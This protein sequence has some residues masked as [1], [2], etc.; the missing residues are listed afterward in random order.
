[1]LSQLPSRRSGAALAPGAH[2]LDGDTQIGR[3]IIHGPQ[4][5]DTRRLV[6]C[7]STTFSARI[8]KQQEHGSPFRRSREKT[9]AALFHVTATGYPRSLH[10]NRQARFIEKPFP[11]PLTTGRAIASTGNARS[12]VRPGTALWTGAVAAAPVSGQGPLRT[13][14][15]RTGAGP[16]NRLRPR[17]HRISLAAQFLVHVVLQRG[18]GVEGPPVRVVAGCHHAAHRSDGRSRRSPGAGGVV[19]RRV[20]RLAA[21]NSSAVTTGGCTH[22]C[23]QTQH[24]R[25][26]RR[27]WWR[28]PQTWRPK[29][30]GFR[31]TDRTTPAVQTPG[32]P[33]SGSS[34]A[35][36][37]AAVRQRRISAM[38]RRSWPRHKKIMRTVLAPTGSI[39]SRVRHL[40]D[41][42]PG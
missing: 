3:D 39:T 14:I 33:V 2:G 35:G 17:L 8:L 23:D 4:P 5:V 28:R 36:Y 38:G 15:S 19:A 31:R 25:G 26:A 29:Y 12:A 10:R 34:G 42:Q 41:A 37:R 20:C 7:S 32:W 22:A 27:P 18:D 11:R 1:M 16:P 24:A 13:T 40:D 30:L 21:R 9:E 6:H